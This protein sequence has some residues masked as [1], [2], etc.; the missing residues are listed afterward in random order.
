MYVPDR[1]PKEEQELQ[2]SILCDEIVKLRPELPI[3]ALTIETDPERVFVISRHGFTGFFSKGKLKEPK[4]F[5][6]MVRIIRNKIREM[7]EVISEMPKAKGWENCRV[8]YLRLRRRHDWQNI[9]SRIAER[10]ERIFEEYLET[11]PPPQR[12][13]G[14]VL[15][16]ETGGRPIIEN[17][18][19]ARRVIF[20]AILTFSGRMHAV[21]ES[22]G[23]RFSKDE[24]EALNP[25]VPWVGAFKT[26]LSTL[27]IRYREFI[28]PK[29]GEPEGILPEERIWLKEF[30]KK[31]EIKFKFPIVG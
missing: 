23:Y 22:L 21:E 16:A 13:L 19:T 28:T 31:K 14:D 18:L 8:P 4:D 12:S 25:M 2:G 30:C 27:G 10:A 24:G 15:G 29:S 3:F 5:D 11:K 6:N 7:E 17:I 26:Y 9:E 1:E 20:A